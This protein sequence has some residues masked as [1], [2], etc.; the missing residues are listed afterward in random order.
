MEA[1]EIQDRGEIKANGE[2]VRRSHPE[3]VGERWSGVRSLR[4]LKW[5][6]QH[7]RRWDHCRGWW[8]IKRR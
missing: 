7:L 1:Q 5:I 2:K 6:K 8:Q 4:G 3:M